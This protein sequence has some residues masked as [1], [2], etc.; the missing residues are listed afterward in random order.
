MVTNLGRRRDQMSSVLRRYNKPKL[1]THTLCRLYVT[2]C[3]FTLL[4]LL[5]FLFYFTSVSL[6]RY[7]PSISDYRFTFQA[8]TVILKD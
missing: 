6:H 3:L 2:V 8:C 5:R 7:L 1:Q 4:H